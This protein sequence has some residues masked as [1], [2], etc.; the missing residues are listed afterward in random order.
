MKSSWHGNGWEAQTPNAEVLAQPPVTALP[1]LEQ[2]AI[3]MAVT[4]RT[5]QQDYSHNHLC[6]EAMGVHAFVKWV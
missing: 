3:G 4:R 6:D 2:F 5:L 1:E